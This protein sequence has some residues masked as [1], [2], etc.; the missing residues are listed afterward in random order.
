[1]LHNKETNTVGVIKS[2]RL[3]LAWHLTTMEKGRKTFKILKD[4]PIGNIPL[5]WAKRRCEDNI[6]LDLK[7]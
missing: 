7:K 6:R 2:R 5:A 3:A 1:M 4:N